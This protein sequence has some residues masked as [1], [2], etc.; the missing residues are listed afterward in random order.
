MRGS[1]CAGCW[2][3]PLGEGWLYKSFHSIPVIH[4]ADSPSFPSLP[5][6]TI[7]SEQI[8]YKE[9]PTI[10]LIG[11]GRVQLDQAIYAQGV[12]ALVERA[13]A[14][15]ATAAAWQDLPAAQQP[16]TSGNDGLCRCEARGGH[17]WAFC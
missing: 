15:A 9:N 16:I 2:L 1:V 5:F 12:D 11:G 13:Q 4:L 14:L 10:S 3:S 8:V 7:L 6:L 17:Y